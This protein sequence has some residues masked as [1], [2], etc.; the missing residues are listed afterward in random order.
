[1]GDQWLLWFIV[2]VFGLFALSRAYIRYREQRLTI[3]SF[4]AWC[5]VWLGVLVVVSFPEIIKPIATLFN[6]ARPIDFF[7]YL[8]IVIIFYLIFRIMIRLEQIDENLTNIVR[9]NALKEAHEKAR[10]KKEKE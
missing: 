6:L 4:L 5:V 7:V 9:D 3:F 8:S 2:V 1:M 10:K